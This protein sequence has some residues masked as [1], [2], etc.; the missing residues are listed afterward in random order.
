MEK[1]DVLTKV[2]AIVGTILA[3]FPILTPVILTTIVFAVEGVFRF[4]YLMPAELFLFGLAGALLLLWAGLRARLHW[5]LIAWGL[6]IAIFFLVGGQALAVVTGLASGEIGPTGWQWILVLT[7]LGIFTL[8][9][10][11]VGVGGILL[12]RDL[13]RKPRLPVT[14]D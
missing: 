12:L 13:F 8:G 3:W 14:T 11:A 5:K 2:L 10:I 7:S 9:L 4:D 6:G 1:R